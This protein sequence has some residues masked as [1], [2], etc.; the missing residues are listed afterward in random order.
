MS[1]K[2]FLYA[3]KFNA[4]AEYYGSPLDKAA[5]ETLNKKTNSEPSETLYKNRRGDIFGHVN[6][7]IKVGVDPSFAYLLHVK[8]PGTVIWIINDHPKFNGFQ[9]V[10]F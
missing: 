10:K 3:D 1:M 2:F 6:S 9:F 8:Y 4:D 7:N 5:E